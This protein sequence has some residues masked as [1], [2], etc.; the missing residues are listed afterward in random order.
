MDTQEKT[1][2]ILERAVEMV[3]GQTLTPPQPCGSLMRMETSGDTLRWISLR[4]Q[5]CCE[6]TETVD[7][8]AEMRI[9]L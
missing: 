5:S 4:P 6:F 1:Q 7:R 2:K 3:V 9:L 8:S